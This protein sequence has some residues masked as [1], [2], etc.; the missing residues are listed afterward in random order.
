MSA[1]TREPTADPLFAGPPAR[2]P[3]YATGILLDAGDFLDEQTYHRGRLARAVWALS[4]GGTL[5][6][7]RV[8]H[9]PE[10]EEREEEIRVGGGLAV[11]R[12]GRLVEV[13]R[14]A[15]LR[16]SRWWSATFASDEG[17]T[18]LRAAYEDPGRFLGERAAG[19]AGTDDLPAVPARAVVADVFVRFVACEEGLTPAFAS[20]PYDALDAASVSRLRDA[21]ELVLV[22]REGLDD[23]FD[24]LPPRGDPPADPQARREAVEDAVLDGWP[25]NGLGGGSDALPPLPEHPV[26]LDPTAV[27]VGRILVP[28]GA[29]SPVERDGAGVVVDNWTRRFVPSIRLLRQLIGT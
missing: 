23:D 28:V 14:T 5:A 17:D 21:Y 10:E 8:S 20:G 19:A 29:G 1:T 15:C 26:G 9:R 24:G 25:P 16:L 3:A 2:R 4:G 27:F 18:L 12:L 22:P 13:P 7:L 11:D 6:G